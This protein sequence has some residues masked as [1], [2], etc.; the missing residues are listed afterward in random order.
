VT[1]LRGSSNRK[2]S[3]LPGISSIRHVAAA[4]LNVRS[5]P[6]RRLLTSAYG[7]SAGA[8]LLHLS[9]RESGML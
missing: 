4:G 2:T 1:L 7:E 8:F 9:A 3:R 6:S 5:S